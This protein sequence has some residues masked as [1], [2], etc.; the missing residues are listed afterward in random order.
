MGHLTAL[1]PSAWRARLRG[2]PVP[3]QLLFSYSLAAAGGAGLALGFAP[4]SYRL[5]SA[6]GML[7]VCLL[8]AS[9]STAR[10]A[11]GIGLS[12]GIGL[13]AVG[14]AWI[15]NAIVG[16]ASNAPWAVGPILAGFV[17]L[18]ALPYA[19]MCYLGA[20]VVRIEGHPVRARCLR[21]ALVLPAAWTLAE[22]L[23]S[24]GPLALPW[25]VLGTAQVPDGAL[26][27]WMPL[28][29]TFGTGWVA[30]TL[31]G[32]V[33][34]AFWMARACH[35]RAAVPAVLLSCLGFAASMPLKGL[36]WTTPEVEPLHVRLWQTNHPQSEKWNRGIAEATAAE[37]IQWVSN[38]PPHSV[39]LTPELVIIDP[40]QGLPPDWTDGLKQA[41]A[42]RDNTLLLGIPS[43]DAERRWFNTLAAIGPHADQA[44]P[45]IYGKER[46]ALFGETLPAK[47]LLGWLYTRA[48]AWPLQDLSAPDPDLNP[49]LLYANGH[50]LAAAICFETAFT[51]DGAQR[52]ARAAFIANPSNDAWFESTRYQAHALQISQAAAMETGKPIL[53][54]NNVGYTAV[55]RPNGTLQA[56]LPSGVNAELAADVMGYTGR[57]PFSH[58]G[59]PAIVVLCA[60]ALWL[61][62]RLARRWPQRSFNQ[63]KPHP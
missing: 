29:G 12:A 58:L 36:T 5:A 10:R 46:L 56:S 17:L 2:R 26:A 14:T 25:M 53:R 63:E 45:Q 28:V 23:R 27:G 50:V 35:M 41:L 4:W 42:A 48:F 30:W 55:I 24:S 6:V 22:W 20:R 47:A 16:G 33:A 44:E 40:W 7:G 18:S 51:R 54:A 32:G 21:A 43:V 39:L 62:R 49:R 59:E 15:V 13:M 9:A 31:I 8:F 60:L 34:S 61:A 3:L 19:L 1:R 11:A 38:A 57:T 37:L 52:D